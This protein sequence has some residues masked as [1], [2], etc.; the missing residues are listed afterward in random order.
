[1]RHLFVARPVAV[2]TPMP[3]VGTGFGVEYDH[4]PIGVAVRSE[5]LPGCHIDGDIGGRPQA[6]RGIAIV[7]MRLP[8]DLQDELAVHR[9]LEELAV[10]LAVSGKP[11]EVFLIEENA[12]L[13]LRPF[14]ARSRTTLIAH[15]IA[16]L[17][18]YQ[19][20]RSGDAALG[21]WRILLGR[22]FARR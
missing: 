21:L 3:L 16:G 13:A 14:V 18:E 17:V 10:F 12:V 4:P 5:H 8:A 15:E 1:M 9:E 11:H 7:A 22:A 6:V 2:G 20:R 19:H